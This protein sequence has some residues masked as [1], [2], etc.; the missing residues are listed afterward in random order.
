MYLE[1]DD[2]CKRIIQKKENIYII[3]TSKINHLGARAVDEKYKNEIE[4]SRNWHW[5]WSKFYFRKKHH[6]YLIA[7]IFGFPKFFSSILKYIFYSI[8]KD[9]AKKKIYFN[10]TSGFLN[11]AMGKTSWY[12]PNINF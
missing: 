2:L 8:K 10:R 4:Y 3:P 6:G 12:R 7:F 5:I 1:N 9:K 11:A